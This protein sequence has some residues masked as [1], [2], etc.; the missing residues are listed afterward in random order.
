MHVAERG[1]EEA[2]H[3]A[4]GRVR[5]RRVVQE[6]H[7][8]VVGRARLDRV[9]ESLPLRRDGQASGAEQRVFA[10][11][12]AAVLAVSSFLYAFSRLAIMEPLLNLWMLLAL[13][14]AYRVRHAPDRR[15]EVLL[16]AG[17]GAVVALMIG[18][19]TTAVALVPAIAYML[20]SA[21]R[22]RV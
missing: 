15:R 10:A 18:T 12:A 3:I 11:A 16:T 8:R 4:R 13:L 5:V 1:H 21:C 14:L 19:K 9:V 7:E 17:L 6:R 2:V 22:W 20:A